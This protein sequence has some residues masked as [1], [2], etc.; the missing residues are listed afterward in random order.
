MN[1][2]N[3]HIMEYI[4]IMKINCKFFVQWLTL[5]NGHLNQHI[6]V[7]VKCTTAVCLILL[8]FL[9]LNHKSDNCK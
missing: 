1:I 8:L 2:W 6:F 5:L 3:L 9:L 7:S 4:T